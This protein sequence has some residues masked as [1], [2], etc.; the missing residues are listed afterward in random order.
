MS[1]TSL[2]ISAVCKLTE[3]VTGIQWDQSKDYLIETRL[4]NRLHEFG[5]KSLEEL[6]RKVESSNGPERNAF[7]DAVTTRETL[8]FRDESPYIALE[9]KALP[10]IIDAKAKSPYARRLRL[11]SA[12]A[13]TGQ[14]AYSM[15]MTL[16]EM[17]PDF[18]RWDVQVTA[19]D[20]SDAALSTASRGIYT[21]FEVGRGMR[22]DLLNR[23]F[24]RVSG[25]WQVKD[26][27]R[28]VV[29]FQ[30][31]NLLQP[32]VNLGPF[33]IIFCRYVAIYFDVLTRRDLFERISRVLTSDG[34]IFVGA[35]ENLSDFGP[36]WLPQFHCRAVYYQPNQPRAAI[37][38]QPQHPL[39][40]ATSASPAAPRFGLATAGR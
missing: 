19:T 13:S 27:V 3:Q 1:L 38:L 12:A 32:F 4:V 5:C 23:Y 33:D 8:F 35:S 30:K 31:A 11:W 15:V 16:M 37:S 17:L 7:I 14:E 22:Q 2:Q 29:T 28:S 9:H 20:I 36:K 40:G 6:L 34:A 10:E 26:E 24:N 18:D 21:D 39:A 25:G